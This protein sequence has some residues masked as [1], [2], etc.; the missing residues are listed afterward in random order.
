MTFF[1]F[2]CKPVFSMK[3]LKKATG[4]K[5]AVAEDRGGLGPLTPNPPSCMSAC[6]SSFTCGQTSVRSVQN[7][8]IR[9]GSGEGDAA[10]RTPCGRKSRTAVA[11]MKRKER[12]LN[13]ISGINTQPNKPRAGPWGW[14][15]SGSRLTCSSTGWALWQPSLSSSSS[16]K[17]TGGLQSLDSL[18]K[19]PVSTF[20]LMVEFQ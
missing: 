2:N 6:M 7:Y 14:A 3:S 15:A 18:R 20:L 10:H 17:Y 16:S 11:K 19:P 5:E 4:R 13:E 12:A 9:K 8:G 1:F